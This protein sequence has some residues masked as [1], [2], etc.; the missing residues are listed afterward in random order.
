MDITINIKEYKD[1]VKNLDQNASDTLGD[2]YTSCWMFAYYIHVKY[3][4]P[5]MNCEAFYQL[6]A[7]NGFDLN[8]NGIYSYLM[9]NDTEIHHFV[10][11]VND[12]NLIMRATY[13][14]QE[15]IIEIKYDKNV[16]NDKFK[17]LINEDNNKTKIKKYCELFGIKKVSFK[18]LDL[19]NLTLS[20]TFKEYV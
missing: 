13:G 12:D 18:E 9:C 1:F 10:L 11:F 19:S 5:I 14:G 15:N 4:L 2:D 3:G 17:E 6:D 8:K 16:F 7:E 20:Y